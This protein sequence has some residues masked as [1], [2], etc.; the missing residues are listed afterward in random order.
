[1]RL[2]LIEKKIA[3][4]Y[5]G[6]ESNGHAADGQ[7]AD[8][9]DGQEDDEE[10]PLLQK[11]EEDYYKVPDGQSRVVRSFPILYCLR[12]P[13]LLTAQ[14]LA[15]TQAT[16]LGTFDATVPTEAQ[17]LFGFDSLK[18]GLLFIALI[19]PQLLGGPIGGWTVDKFGPKPAAVAGFGFLV[20]TL[21]L[22]RL[23]RPGGT[24]QIV[25]YCALLALN[26]IGMA[27]IGSPSIV[28][29][30][31]VVQKYDKAN[32][33][34]FGANGPYAQLYSINSMVF[35]AGLTIGPLVSGSLRDAVGYGNM[36]IAV[37]MLCM[38]TSTL[39]FVYIGGTPKV[40]KRRR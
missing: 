31:D 9:E 35:S 5:E 17:D 30:S 20:P 1:M 15:L 16:L 11:K 3:V 6:T 36:N 13:R 32:P 21:I 4:Q 27:V 7:D 29:A 26:G 40:L 8:E 38:V 10:E 22:L 19:L 2:L 24:P 23:A 18:A 25:L 28:E 14:L 33:G 37:A 34:F 39:S 12:D